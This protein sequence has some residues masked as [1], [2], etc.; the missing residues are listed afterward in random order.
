MGKVGNV[1]WTDS[2]KDLGIV[3]HDDALWWRDDTTEEDARPES[4]GDARPE[5]GGDEETKETQD[6]E[7]EDSKPKAKPSVKDE[8][9]SAAV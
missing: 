1:Y 8:K 6:S 7:E 4:G 3:E 9:T 2:V 5:S